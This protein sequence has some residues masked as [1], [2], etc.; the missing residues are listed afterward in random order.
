MLGSHICYG[1]QRHADVTK[2]WSAEKGEGLAHNDMQML[3]FGM[4]RCSRGAMA[5]SRQLC[6]C[7]GLVLVN[8]AGRIDASYIPETAAEA[9]ATTGKKG[10]PALVADLVSRG[11]FTYLERSIAK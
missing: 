9:A 3:W 1:A 4:A 6:A 5:V 8:S 10:P 2:E 7:A 11:L